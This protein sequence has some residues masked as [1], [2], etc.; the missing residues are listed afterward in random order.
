[1]KTSVRGIVALIRAGSGQICGICQLVGVVGPLGLDE[2]K[3]HI[4]EH[5]MPLESIS[6]FSYRKVFAWVLDDAKVFSAPIPYEHPRGAMVWV[7]LPDSIL[8]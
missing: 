7:R 8:T 2:L 1:M 5:R 3:I 6:G 4:T